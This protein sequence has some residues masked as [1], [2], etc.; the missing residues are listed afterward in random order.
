M[1]NYWKEG[2]KK[3]KEVPSSLPSPSPS[4]SS[5]LS[6]LRSQHRSDSPEAEF[7]SHQES[8]ADSSVL[9]IFVVDKAEYLSKGLEQS[10]FSLITLSWPKAAEWSTMQS[11]ANIV[12]IQSVASAMPSRK[13][14][15]QIKSCSVSF[16]GIQKPSV[17]VLQEELKNGKRN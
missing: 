5:L 17:L 7:S 16:G 14:V 11:I 10:H 4:S 6:E 8:G 3:D 13:I 12:P 2:E 9:D 15:G 1:P